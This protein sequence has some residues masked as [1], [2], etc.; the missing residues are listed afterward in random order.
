MKKVLYPVMIMAFCLVSMVSF[1]QQTKP[2]PEARAKKISEKMKTELS[3]SD[4]QYTKVYDINLKYAEKMKGLRN[5]ESDK[6]T[7]MSSMRDL[8]KSKNEELKGVLSEEQ[9]NKYTDMQKEMKHKA[10]EHRKKSA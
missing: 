6:K 5:E 7:K 4:D 8:N 1:S 3:L 10:R 9:M 2:D